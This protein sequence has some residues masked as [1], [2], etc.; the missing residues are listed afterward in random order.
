IE[1]TAY[2]YQ[3]L[4]LVP[5]PTRGLSRH[6]VSIRTALAPGLEL[7]LPIVGANMGHMGKRMCATLARLGAIGILYQDFDLQDL[8]DRIAGVKAAHPLYELPTIQ[9]P[10]ATVGMALDFMYKKNFQSVVVVKDPDRDL[11]PIG[12]CSREEM[13]KVARTEKLKNVM[14]PDPVTMRDDGDL[15]EANRLMREQ[16]LS[17]V[18]VVDRDGRLVGCIT[19]RD[20]SVRMKYRYRPAL[21]AKGR[22]RVGAALGLRRGKGTRS[23]VAL[24]RHLVEL[25]ADVLVLDVANGYLGNFLDFVKAVRAELGPSVP[26]IAGNVATPQ[27][28]EGLLEAGADCVKVGIGPGGACTTRVMTGVGVPQASAVL[29]CAE[30]TRQAGK[31]CIADGGVREPRDMALALAL[32]ADAVMVGSALAPTYESA[33]DELEKDGRLFKQWRGN[34]S[35]EAASRRREM[36]GGQ[37]IVLEE[38][39]H[40]EGHAGLVPVKGS[41]V[42]VLHRFAWGV[43]SACTYSN[44]LDLAEFRRNAVVRVQTPAGY[45]EGKPHAF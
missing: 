6:E 19:P 37:E 31:A 23:P 13:R 5:Q 17:D 30:V 15:F 4:F 45:A 16:H 35:A 36:I 29:E 3:D 2:T 18:P 43:H 14:T 42:H 39:E 27:G 24:A 21:D 40:A 9:S 8:E 34:A 7:P 12:I 26:L 32:G 25:G 1:K 11:T 22:L 20:L 38:L 41:A 10:D 33:F 28:V 44:A